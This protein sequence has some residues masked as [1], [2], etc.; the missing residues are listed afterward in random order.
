MT[1]PNQ[2]THADTLAARELVK[3][4]VT[5]AFHRAIDA[6]E[7]DP[8]GLMARAMAQVIRERQGEEVADG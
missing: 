5:P 2:F 7:F 1:E 8:W 3:G 6:G 4:W